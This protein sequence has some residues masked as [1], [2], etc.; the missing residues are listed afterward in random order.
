M[1]ADSVAA[2]LAADAIP[3]ASTELFNDEFD[4]YE[5]CFSYLLTKGPEV[6]GSI[7]ACVFSPR[8]RTARI[9]ALEVYGEEVQE[10]LGSGNVIVES[11]RFVIDPKFQKRTPAS[12]L[13]LFRAIVLNARSSTRQTT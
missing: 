2:Y 11:N 4:S 5:N 3:A 10:K 6:I 9:P 13:H 8:F 7:R 1:I 12:T